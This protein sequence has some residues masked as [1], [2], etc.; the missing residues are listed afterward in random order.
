[1]IYPWQQQP[2]QLLMQRVARDNLPHSMLITGPQGTGKSDFAHAFA[3]YLLCT[4]EK[5]CDTCKGCHW[6]NANSHPDYYLVEPEEGKSSISI[7]Q[8]RELVTKLTKTSTAGGY[9]VVIIEGAQRMTTAASNALL[10]TLEEP[11]GQVV[12]MLVTAERARLPATIISR[13]QMVNIEE[14]PT[15]IALEWL[16][17]QIT[18]PNQAESLLRLAQGRVLLA[19]QYAQLDMLTRFNGILDDLLALYRGSGN[20]LKLA[21]KW[22]KDE[23]QLHLELLQI[24]VIMMVRTKMTG[25]KNTKIAALSERWQQT[26]LFEYLTQ[27]QQ[28]L[29]LLKSHANPNVQLLLEGLLVQ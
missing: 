20:P 4:G 6:F 14:P 19:K 29:G 25:A 2:W 24:V 18:E 15:T 1:M 13:C 21:A 28:K 12:F 9:Q 11:N 27:V 23:P 7:N 17:S 22:Q 10:K 3:H 5:I 8:I 16:Q 26:A